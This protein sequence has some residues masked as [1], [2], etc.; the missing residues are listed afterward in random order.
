MP[1]TVAP[2]RERIV[3]L[4]ARGV[5]CRA[6]HQILRDE[7]GFAGAYQSVYRFVRRLEPRTPDAVVRVETPP[8]FERIPEPLILWV[9]DGQ[10][11][12]WCRTCGT[13]A[14]VRTRLVE[15]GTDPHAWW[16]VLTARLWA[17]AWT[18][19]E[20]RAALEVVE[21]AIVRCALL[22]ASGPSALAH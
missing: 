14:V 17:H 21:A 11:T 20:L 5:E 6:I 3:A 2:F 16:S 18:V 8:H 19:A 10:L 9:E 7:C 12:A 13:Q 22:T 15:T 1:S 4:R